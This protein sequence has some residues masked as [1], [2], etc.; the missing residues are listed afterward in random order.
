MHCPLGLKAIQRLH[1]E[2][3]AKKGGRSGA[4]GQCQRPGW[5][6]FGG[7]RRS[8]GQTEESHCRHQR[9]ERQDAGEQGN[10][11]FMRDIVVPASQVS[12]RA[13]DILE[14]VPPDVVVAQTE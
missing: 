9:A 5:G 11:G 13:T 14:V 2:G 10:L 8:S 4:Q 1:Q 12:V 6:G 3:N 7:S